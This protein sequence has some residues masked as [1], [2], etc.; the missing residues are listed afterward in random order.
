MNDLD[1]TPRPRRSTL[2][3]DAVR[4][5]VLTSDRPLTAEEIHQQ[6][7]LRHPG[8]GIATVYRVIQ[9]LMGEGGV[10]QVTF[11]GEGQQYYEPR[12]RAGHHHFRCRHCDRAF[13][14]GEVPVMWERIVP[15]GFLLEEH[16]VTLAGL[17]RDCRSQ[18]TPAV[19]DRR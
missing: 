1:L 17:C 15:A 5:V 9:R 8:L 7:A 2:Q 19:T 14:L 12:R 18:T 4:D 6:A 10:Q 3:G 11:P 13:C 16:Q